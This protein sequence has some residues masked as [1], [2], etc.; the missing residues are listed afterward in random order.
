ME[1]VDAADEF[2]WQRIVA[3]EGD[4]AGEADLAAVRVAGQ[5]EIGLQK[6][7][8][9]DEVWVVAE[10][11]AE[12]VG[13]F[14]AEGMEEGGVE[15]EAVY[16]GEADEFECGGAGMKGVAAVI[17]VGD[18]QTREQGAEEIAV[19]IAE[20]HDRAEAG[21]EGVDEFLD[22]REFAA[23]IVFIVDEVAGEGDQIGWIGAGAGDEVVVSRVPGGAGVKIAQV[24]DAEVGEVIGEI[25][26]GEFGLGPFEAS[27]GEELEAGA[28]VVEMDGGVESWGSLV[29][30]GG[31]RWVGWGCCY[32]FIFDEPHFFDDLRVT[33]LISS[34][35]RPPPWPSPGVKRRGKLAEV[36]IVAAAWLHRL[37]Y[38]AIAADAIGPPAYRRYFMSE[39]RY[40]KQLV[41]ALYVNAAL[42]LAILVVLAGRGKPV[43]EMANAQAASPDVAAPIAGGGGIFVMPCQ[44]HPEVW[45]CYLLDTQ[46]Q[47][48]CVYEYRAGEKA[49]VLSAARNFRFDLDLKNYN[50]FPAW[51]VIKKAVDEAAQNEKTNESQLP[52]VVPVAPSDQN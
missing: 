51:Y 35:R 39:T 25:G 47:T 52:G 22:D 2:R 38:A 13:V 43:V 3:E 17:D 40:S 33:V 44:L 36:F 42:L 32:A 37:R 30:R 15:V 41:Y 9:A 19:V 49:L 50:T 29:V 8:A 24:E 31:E 18:I 21:G 11:D 27:G 46:R 48:M 20:D 34:I 7:R 14:V 45:G 5:K 10:G 12:G 4:A 26:D 1:A 28:D 6:P 16:A 23:G